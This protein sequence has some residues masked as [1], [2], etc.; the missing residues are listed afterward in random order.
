[1]NSCL[2]NLDRS[3]FVV[4]ALHEPSDEKSYWLS[5]SPYARLEAIEQMRQIV[6]GY[7]PATIRLQ[8][9]LVITERA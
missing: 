6:Y 8:R 1:M 3:A 9:I 2:P 5:K 7:N 4:S